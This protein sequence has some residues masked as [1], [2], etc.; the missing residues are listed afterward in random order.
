MSDEITVQMPVRKV[1]RDEIDDLYYVVEAMPREVVGYSWT[2]VGRGY[3][4]STSAYAKLGRM[5]A[6]LSS[7]AMDT[8]NRS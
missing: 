3:P 1:K 2:K 7:L 4:H 5:T 6:T 8:L